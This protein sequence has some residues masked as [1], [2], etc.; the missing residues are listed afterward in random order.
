MQNIA[1]VD[2]VIEGVEY[3]EP[4]PGET[5]SG[6][7]VAPEAER[8]ADASSAETRARQADE[9]VRVC[10][11]LDIPCHTIRYDGFDIGSVLADH[12]VRE[13]TLRL[14]LGARVEGE[15]FTPDKLLVR[16]MSAG[17]WHIAGEVV[18]DRE[19][20]NFDS[21]GHFSF[22]LPGLTAWDSLADLAVEL[23]YVR[24]GTAETEFYVDSV[25]VDARYAVVDEGEELQLAPNILPEL[26]VLEDSRRPDMLLVGDERI[27]LPRTDAVPGDELVIRSDHDVYDGLTRVRSYL[28]VTNHGDTEMYADLVVRTGRHA[29][30][31]G[32]RERV[33]AVPQ[34]TLVPEYS[35]VAYL[36][37]GGW[38][39]GSMSQGVAA[40]SDVPADTNT[41]DGEEV[42]DGTASSSV[43]MTEALVSDGTGS[44]T[45]DD[46]G[47]DASGE[48]A[49]SEGEPYTCAA[50][51]EE[52]VCSSLN[53][54]ETNCIAEE[55]RI[56][57]TEEVAYREGWQ[58]VGLRPYR[59]RTSF[60]QRVLRSEATT[61]SELPN[62]VEAE[63]RVRLA[64][65]ETRFF[66]VDVEVGVQRAGEF[67]FE[68]RAGD[69]HAERRMWWRSGYSRRVPLTVPRVESEAPEVPLL[70]RV[71]IEEND[72]P[73]F[74]TTARLDGGDVRF[75]D[76]ALRLELPSKVVSFSYVEQ[77]AEYLVELGESSTQASSSIF[78]YYGNDTVMEASRMRA[79]SQTDTPIEYVRAAESATGAL[80]SVTS[81]RDGNTMRT[82]AGGTEV[83]LHEGEALDMVLG[84]EPL[85]ARGP[86]LIRPADTVSS[87][88]MRAF[89]LTLP[90]HT[91]SLAQGTS[92]LTYVVERYAS[93]S[94]EL[95]FGDVEELPVP[96]V[97]IFEPLSFTDQLSRILYLRSLTGPAYHDFLE[98]LRDF[99]LGDEVVFKLRYKP[100]RW[101]ITRF[102][103][104]LVRDRLATV[105]GVR[106]LYGGEVLTD[107][108]FDV[109][110]GAEGEWTIKLTEAPRSLVP[111]K[112]SVE[113]TIDEV[114]ELYTD[115]FDF[116]FGVL[117]VNTPEATYETGSVAE[118]HMAALDDRGDTIC[119]AELR[120]LITPPSGLAEEIPVE[121]S[122]TCGPNNVTDEPDYRALYRLRESGT[123]DLVL[124]HVN[125]E[126]EIVHQVRDAVHAA[127][128]MPYTIE[129]AG[130][131]RIWPKAP[132]TMHLTVSAR[133][134]W[135]G[136]LVEALPRDFVVTDA[137]GGESS[138]WGGAKRLSWELTL[139]A[140]ESVTLSYEYD[141]PDR[142][143]YLYLLGP[144]ELRV[145]EQ[146]AYRE[147]KSWKLASDALGQYTE[148]YV[149]FTP[150]VN[151]TWTTIDLSGAPY[152]IPANAILEIAI[153]NVDTGNE[154]YGGVRSGAST[155]LD[156]RVRIHEAE[157]SGSDVTTMFVQA[158][159]TSSIQY[160]SDDTNDIRFTILGYW[161]SGTYTE[162]WSV[163]GPAANNWTT[164]WNLNTYGVA[165]GNVA[166]IVLVN[167]DGSNEYAAGVRT[168]GSTL[169]REVTIHEPEQG[170]VDTA[171]ML[172][173]A[174]TSN[175][176]IRYRNA[177][178]AIDFYVAGFFSTLP[179]GL[180]YYER[181][182][183]LGGPASANTWTDRRLDDI[184][185]PNSAI[186]DVA[187]ANT[188]AD[189]TTVTI[190][191]RANGSSLSRT[192]ELHEAEAGG[193]NH[194]RSHVTAGSDAS[195]T[196]EYFT[197][198]TAYD[199]F[200]LAGYWAAANYPPDAPTLHDIPFDNEKTGSST[201]YF[202]FTASDPDGS[203]DIVYQVQWDD[204]ADLDASPLGDRSSDN[205]T[206]CSPNCFANTVSGG[207]TSPFTE[208]Q[209]I[210]FSIQSALTSGTT[211][212]WRVRAKDSSGS[213]IYS[214]WTEVRS[215]TYVADTNPKAWYQTADAQFDGGTFSGAETY[216]A[217]SVRLATTPPV[218]AMVAY[219]EGTV[220]TP[221]Y[222]I[223]N[224]TAWG[225]EL[226]AQSATG[227]ISW[228]V[229]RAAPTRDEY[230]LVTQTATGTVL[231]QVYNGT[232]GTWGN[233]R[234]MTSAAPSA[235]RR[236]VDVAYRGL[237]GEAVV[238][239][240]DGDTDP[241]TNIW[242]GTNWSA[243]TTLDTQFNSACNWVALA[244]SDAS[245]EIAAVVQADS[246][247]TTSDFEAQILTG[248]T[249]GNSYTGGSNTAG[250]EFLERMSIAYEESGTEAVVVVGNGGTASF[251]SAVWNTTA[252]T[253][254]ANANR[255][256][257]DDFEW[258]EFAVDDG[259]DN[260]GLCY[261]DEDNQVHIA[262]WNG[263]SNTWD[264]Y[265]AAGDQIDTG[266]KAN[267]TTDYHARP[268][269]CR[270]ETT[271]GRDGYLMVPYSDT[272]NAR[273]RVWSTSLTVEQSI[274]TIEDSWTVSSARTG[275]GLIL[276][277]WRDDT[278]DR[279]DFSYWNGNSWSAR[280]ALESSM[281]DDTEPYA[282]PAMIAAQRFQASAGSI[283]S[284]IIDFDSVPG[285]SS[286]GELLWTTTEPSGTDVVMQVYYATTTAVC[287]VL[288]PDAAL[289]GNSTGF[290][291][292][293]SPLNLSGL[294]TS[295]YNMLCLKASLSSQSSQ[296]STLDEW[297]VSWVRQPFLTQTAYR[298]YANTDA[299][300]PTDVWPVGSNSVA[301]NEAISTA[302]A[303]NVGDVLRLR[304][305]M[306][307]S[308]VTL[309][310]SSTAF[311]LQWAEGVSC[312]AS[313]DWQ[314]VGASGSSVAWRGYDN[315]S[316]SDG[317]TLSS[318]LLSTTDVS[319]S[320]EEVNDTATNTSAL[321]PTEEAEF[322]FVL[323][324][325][326]TS[327]TNY[328]FRLINDDGLPINQ[329]DRYPQLITNAPPST[330]VLATPF[331]YEALAS[332]TP[333]FTFV[334]ED[335]KGDDI[336]YEIEI[337][338]DPAFGSPL[339]RNSADHFNEFV[340]TVT[341]ADKSPFTSGEQVR[342][343][344]TTALT[345]N[346]T[347]WWRVHARDPSGSN[348]WSDWS[349]AWSFTASSTVSI[350]TWFQTTYEQFEENDHENTEATVSDD[351]ALI[352][353][354]TLG[355]TTAPGIK[356]AWKTTGNAW[357]SLS[358]TE[359]ETTG[360]LRT[361]VQYNNNGIWELIPDSVLSGNSVG[362]AAGPVSLLGLDPT[363]YSEIRPVAYLQD[364]SGSPRLLDWTLSWGL[365]VEQP[366]LTS[367]FDNEKVAT[368]TPSFTF[369]STDPQGNDLTYEIQ[370][371]AT[372]DFA[373]STTRT[374][375]THTG[376]TN[377]ASSTDTSPFLEDNIIRFT[378][379]GAD[380]LTN[381][382]TYWWRVRA[383]DPGG[384]DT[385]S[386][387]SPIRSLTVDT[388][389]TVSTWFQTTDE[390]FDTDFLT[391][392]ETYGSD[393]VRITSTIREALVAYAEG[394]VQTPRY[395][396]WN[397]NAWGTEK[398]AAN[399][400]ERIY[401]IRTAAGPA[402]DEY[403][404]VTG[405]LSGAVKA[406]VYNGTTGQWGDLVD[407]STPAA[408]NRRGF[409]VAY[410]S[411][412]GRAMAA[413]CRGADAVYRTW[414]GA[415]WSATSTINLGFTQNC[416]WLTLASD[417]TSNEIILAARA[418]TANTPYAFEA[419]VWNG[420]AWGNST[421]Q[422][423]M[424]STD[425]ENIGMAVA[426]E[427]SGDQALFVTS[428]GTN[429]N[430]HWRTWNGAWSG[431]SSTTTVDDLETPKIAQDAG[432]DALGLCYITNLNS[433][434]YMRWDG[435]K[436][437]SAPTQFSADSNSK[438]GGHAFDCA[439]ETTAGRDGYLMMPYTDG[440]LGYYRFH[441]TSTGL[442]AEA[443]LSSVTDS[444]SVESVRTG[445]G[446]ILAVFWDDANTQFDFSYWNGTAPW[447]AR[448]T[449]ET[450]VSTIVN[451]IVPVSLTP[452]RYT[453]FTS[454]TLVSDP[455][456]FS[457]G[458]GP[459]WGVASS[460]DT[461]PG[462]SEIRYQFEHSTDNGE[463]WA[464]IPDSALPGNSV[465]TT[466]NT[467]DLSALSYTTYDVI[468]YVANFAC[469][470]GDCPILHDWTIAWSEG[471]KVSGTA[472]G[473]DE[474][475]NVTSGTVAVAVNGAVQTGKTASISGG[476]W[477][478][479]NVTMFPGDTVHVW[480]Q[481]AADANEA[482]AVF[483]YDG[484]GDTTGVELF[485]RHLTIGSH[486]ATTTTN[487][488]IALYDNS[489]SGNEDLFFEVDSGNDLTVC[490]VG[491]CSDAELFVAQGYTY[492]P[493][494][495]SGGNV[496]THDMEIA[497]TLTADGNTLTVSG[498]WENRGIFTANSSSVILRAT[499]SQETLSSVGATTSAFNILTLGQTS[500]NATWTLAGPLEVDGNCTL[501]Y[502][503]LN[504]S[505]SA[506]FLGGNFSLAAGTT[507]LKST[508]TT[509]FD[510]TGVAVITDATAAKQDLGKVAASGTSKTVRLGSA[511]K[512]TD[513]TIYT[514]NTFD[515]SSN[516][517]AL[518]VRGDFRN[519]DSFS[520]R[521]GTVTM[522]ATTTGRTLV[523]GNS[524]LYDL[525]F[526]GVGG[527]WAFGQP[528]VTVQNNLTIATGT[529][530]LATGTTTVSGSLSNSGTLVHNN[531]TLELTGSGSKTLTQGGSPLYNLTVNGAGAWSWTEQNATS[532]GST[533][534]LNGTLTM[535]A[536]TYAV[537]K[538]FVN[539]G[540]TVAPNGGTLRFT[541]NV[542]ETVQANGSA[543]YGLTFDGAGGTFAL[544]DTN[545]VAS[546]TVRFVA[547][548]TTL[549]SG[550]MTVSGSWVTTGGTWNA[551]GGTVLF[552]SAATG[553]TV[554]TGTNNFASVTFNS[555]VGGWSIDSH[556]TSTGA[557]SLLAAQ[558]YT[559]ASGNTMAVGGAFVNNV[560][561]ATTWTGSTLALSSGTSYTVGSSSQA[562]ET[563]GTLRIGANTDVKFWQS[564]AASYAVDSTGS[565]YSQDHAAQNGDLYIWGEYVRT[566][567]TEHWSYATD[568][569]GTDIGGSPRQ[570][571]VRFA[572]GASAQFTGATLS[573]RGD[574]AATTTLA[575]QG[576]GSYRL[577]LTGST[578]L[579]EYF[580]VANT[581]ADG[582]ALMASTTVNY[583]RDGT[584][585]LD[586]QGGSMLTLASTT[587]DKN[588]LLQP[589]RLSFGTSTGISTGYNVTASG[590]A[591]SY[592]W[593]KNTSGNYDGESYDNDPVAGAGSIRWD[594]SG[595]TIN[596]SGT[597]YTGEGAGV[598]AYC[599]GS[600]QVLRLVVQGVTTYDTSC[601]AGT[602]AFTFSGVTYSGDVTFMAFLNGTSGR[603]A[604]VSRTPQGNIAG[605][606]LYQDRVIVRHEDTA[607][608][609]IANM[610]L[611]DADQ[612]LDI[613]FDAEAGSLTVSPE[614]G[615]HVWA[616]KTFAPSGNVT[617]QSG[618]SG[619]VQD[620]TLRLA[621][622]SV[623]TAAGSESHSIGGS[624]IANTGA[625]FTAANSTVNFT[626]TTT[627]KTIAP[628][629]SFHNL[630]F[631]GLNG[632]W[633]V[634]SSTQVAN[635]LA[636]SAGT[637]SGTGN[638][639]VD[640]GA[641]SG[642]GSVTMTG[643]T[644]TV[645][646]GG[647][648]GGNSTWTFNNLTLGDG[649]SGTTAKVGSGDIAVSGALTV[650]ANHIL[651]AGSYTWTLTGS[652]AVLLVPGTF[653]AQTSTTTFAG[654]GAMTVPALTYHNLVLAPTAAGSP[655]YTLAAGSLTANTVTVGN[656]T[657]PVTVQVNTNDPL[658]TV[659]GTF[660]NRTNATYQA[661]SAND[662]M[663]A[664]SY[665]NEGTFT[666]NGG[667]VVMN[668][669]DT[670][671]LVT[672]GASSFHHLTFN[673]ASGG[674]TITGNATTTGN[675]TLTAA[676]NFTQASGSTLRVEG[677]FL[678]SVG[679]GAT[680]WSGTTLA[681]YSGT[682]YSMNTKTTEGDTYGTLSVGTNTDVAMWNSTSSSYSISPSGSLYSQDHN[683]VDGALYIWGDYT[684]T[685][686][687]EHWSYATDFDGTDISGT[688]RQAKVYLAE[689]A[690]TTLSAGTWNILG[691]SG[692]TT[693]IQNQGSGVYGLK[694]AGGTF[695]AQYY[696]VRN[697]NALGLEFAGTPTVTSLSDGDLELGI[698]GGAMLTIP[699]SVIT[700]N[701]VKTW[702]RVSFATSS[703]VTSGRNATSS[704]T[705][706]SSWR[707]T[708]A[709]GNYYGEAYDGDPAG[710]PGY[711]IWDDS[712]AQVS[713][714]G[715]VYSNETGTVSALCNGS[716]QVVRMVIQGGS[717]QSTSCAAGTGAYLFTGVS[718]SP[719]DAIVV[720]LDNAAAKAAN[721]TVDPVTSIADMHLYESRVVVRHEDTNAITIA[722]LAVYDSDQDTDI[723]FDADTGSPNTLT[724][725]ANR[726]LIVW[727]GKTF[728]PGGNVTLTSGGSG[729]DYDGTL[730]LR[731][732]ATYVSS[733]S[734]AETISVG[735]SWLTGASASFTAGTSTVTFTATTSGK[736]VSPDRSAFNNLTF[737]GSGGAW[738]F[739][740]RDATT[741]RNFTLTAGS[742]TL[743]TS[744]LAVGG[745]FVNSGTL[746]AASTSIRFSAAAPATVT[747]G[748]ASVGSLTF[749]GAGAHTITD[750]SATSTGSVSITAG[751][752]ALPTSVFAVANGFSA[753]GG[754]FT[755]AGTLRLYGTLAAQTLRVGASTLRHLLI[756]GSGSW[757]FADTAATTTGTTTVRAG[758]LTAPSQTF[759][760]GGSFTNS[761]TY[762]S[763]G[764]T[765]RFYATTTGQTI[766]V[767]GALLAN[768]IISGT[769]GGWTVATS[770]TTTGAFR[771]QTATAFEMASSTALEVQGQFENTVGG[772]A[773]NWTDSRLYLNASG[774]SYAVNG[775]SSTGDTYAFLT[776]GPNTD[777][778]MWNSSAATTT[779]HAS[780]SLYAMDHA[781][782]DGSLY[783]WGEYVRSAG[784]EYWSYATDFDGAAL[785]GSARA[786]SV[787]V[788]S[789]STLTFTGGSLDMVGSTGATTSV[790]VIGTG[791]YS[792]VKS[793]GSLNAQ[794]YSFRNLTSQGLVL[795]NAITVTSLSYGDFELSTPNGVLLQ[796]ASSTIDQNPTKTIVGNRF[797]STSGITG[798]NVKVNGTTAN[799]WDFQ[800][801]YGEID[802]ESYDDD[803]VDACGAVRWDD[804]TCLEVSQAHFRFRND[805][806][807]GG[808]PD[809]E[810]YN[811]DWSK[812]VRLNV[813]NQNGTTLT[814]V[815]VRMEL[816]YDSD[817]QS[818]WN[819]IRFTDASGTTSLPYF[820]ER[821]TTSATATIWVKV[822]SIPANGYA[823]L[824]AYYGNAFAANDESG[825]NTFSSFDDFEDD[826]ISEYSGD[827]GVFDVVADS[828]AEGSYILKAG[829]GYENDQTTDG[830]YRTGTTFGQG[831]T[832]RF[833]QYVDATKDDEPC[834]LFGVQSPGSNNQNY[835]V[836]LDQ[837]PS[838]R[839]VLAK[840]VSSNDGSGTV[841]ASSSIAWSS[842]WYT[843]EVDWFTNN[844]IYVSVYNS[845]GSLVA[846]TTASDASYAS[847]GMG[848]SF[849]YQSG[850]WDF[851]TARPYAAVEPTLSSI[852]LEQGKSGASWKAA[853][854]V[855]VTQDQ[856]L[857][858]RVRF[859]VENSGP[860]I[861][862]KQWRLQYA[863]KTGYGTCNAVP[864]VSF[865]DVPT[866]SNCGTNAIC[867]TTTSQYADGDATQ[868]LLTSTTFYRYAG[869]KLIE[870][871]SNQTASS[872]LGQGELTEVEYAIE[873]TQNAVSNA[874]C[875]RVSD[876]GV[877]LDSYQTLAEVTANYGPQI[878]SWSLN[879]DE[880]I[881]LTEGQTTSVQAT[882]TI[883]DLNGFEDL[884]YATGTIYRSA[885]GANCGADLNNCYQLSSLSCPLENCDGTSCDVTCTADIQYFA[886]PTDPG[887]PHEAQSWLA[888]VFVVDLTGNEASS[889]APGVD[890]LTMRAV[891]V[892]TGGIGYGS[893]QVN[894]DTGSYNATSTLRNTGNT[895]VDIDIEGADLTAGAS[896]IP[897][898]NQK[899]ATS[900]FTYSA[901]AICTALS[902]TVSDYE[903]DLPKPTSTSTP[904]T[905]DLYWGIYVPSNA[906]GLTH[907]GQNT[908]Y[909]ISD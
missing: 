535:P 736:V 18:I 834:A 562:A 12:T 402:R 127:E 102:F 359:N 462:A 641:F 584:F 39:P 272:T 180:E 301:E 82:G 390:Q 461:T 133:E 600:T 823:S 538:S 315:A 150:T 219:G 210:R 7:E 663:I 407:M 398:S 783:I 550:T 349:V 95:R 521:A 385:W 292:T 363:L 838:D 530:T 853:Q 123:Y 758:A 791:A 313:M 238:T 8:G 797:A 694:V 330:P 413:A 821:Y 231:A 845:S 487:A 500:G 751:T 484:V 391:D 162:R 493:D 481:G 807:G 111:G 316:V 431:T 670:G 804:S 27:T 472:K 440:T 148:S 4:A 408:T 505:T 185:V 394:V 560:P 251:V 886:E 542:A 516:N 801:H 326:A 846:T 130:A 261:I 70:Y 250:E 835:A 559:V 527:N 699:A 743:G 234:V 47:P 439:Y 294:S 639:T 182:D 126:G 707:F 160:Y 811:A 903:L 467:V 563:Y 412:S 109:S 660:R 902:G 262:K 812:R 617:L 209:R 599:N 357:G 300:T 731:D 192:A 89:A 580:S 103:R 392:L 822:P 898:A 338:D 274:S 420:S 65:R 191:V 759:A 634:A 622:G 135:S 444:W 765:M 893:L 518:E 773:T 704:G 766:S 739:A 237:S 33:R 907:N 60:W 899:F 454:G 321:A 149:T 449:L 168:L 856:G 858:F 587:I 676:S 488:H 424:E 662:L 708:P 414:D 872:S 689:G 325:N 555:A 875:M 302:F 685:S 717:P 382:A 452:R 843:V 387:W 92:S 800:S 75:Y 62:A 520:A 644:V 890:M 504:G 647:N 167:T 254:T 90:A 692:A 270:Y 334:A 52:R 179:T 525:T 17:T 896:T 809:S 119:D 456:H 176:T 664:G 565:L 605:F 677:I 871:P 215:F 583:L 586:T 850:G 859:S 57:T 318:R 701:P 13:Y 244:A 897:A 198:N 494:S 317:A 878:T 223:W 351:V 14:S 282:E 726:K 397:G 195:S 296:S 573:L 874:Y 435:S 443:A 609:S 528:L 737:N 117:A 376:F 288:V 581:D 813:R 509:T 756:D 675:F 285:Q 557:W 597:V 615:L 88:E 747:F 702:Y 378:V 810:W 579:A 429:A 713:I 430:F 281:A 105:A 828:G 793:G 138:V 422:G 106:L 865:N 777:V 643:G 464:L 255:G 51:G 263:T 507:F 243:T 628:S 425:A 319:F 779:V 645:N 889:T 257:Q 68:L 905:D 299:N 3:A 152:S 885:L 517:Y 447:S 38:Q 132:Y 386:V 570:V 172:V 460:T 141:A 10:T 31:V 556:A 403:A 720:Y 860:T 799:F 369:R 16:Y 732:N 549:P 787:R 108:R 658:I 434:Y 757:A 883:T 312:S 218:G 833:L 441:N 519:S 360:T 455:I 87:K 888:K 533:R 760:I 144:A 332:T 601:A 193:Q 735:G 314:D 480:I 589:D 457:D 727:N 857:P 331:T 279:F 496:S 684:R 512:L 134:D 904:V 795:S 848:F 438:D 44:A 719:G 552:N 842:A 479:N 849:W 655:T 691:T 142:S 417:P 513:L 485:E 780:S 588:P 19:L 34:S 442:S 686:G 6:A 125:R 50:T 367:P 537:G 104:G 107:A 471:L 796:V 100:Q 22:P 190:G 308:N 113:L 543:L 501:S 681:L 228:T 260:L 636:V 84:E 868:E 595:F 712:N 710:D 827:T 880:P 395:R 181:W 840:N 421:A 785:G 380:A 852:G 626:A 547:G 328:C 368:V 202:E 752:V 603:G 706:A 203:S 884:L 775:K 794:Y 490:S 526:Q 21:G 366:T 690:S 240:C 26:A 606:D 679:G 837:Y 553:R 541:S 116:Y 637:V 492:R 782:V 320:Y 295:T 705:T 855:S 469:V 468:R 592:W 158:S 602:G 269:T 163:F 632:G 611:Y 303:P 514:G 249:W 226:S 448:Q 304:L 830:I 724:L 816:P 347:Y 761:A 419:Q 497:G 372:P 610:L 511:L 242:N 297:T 93:T 531:G 554:T 700:T 624:W 483:R 666:A 333:W 585:T 20:S 329:Y 508:G 187:Y 474:S 67:A 769:G 887:A 575:N 96:A 145:G 646:K 221:R 364:V 405:G 143:P 869:G 340:N 819:D 748:G 551:N 246:T 225:G 892:T 741:T 625:T 839:L 661:A 271:A 781:G 730:E 792:I 286:W 339:T 771:L 175:A 199:S 734:S 55:E 453:S 709:L 802:G 767:G 725:P 63:E 688:P 373:A 252:Q 593:F 393:Q 327:S 280:A 41:T 354:N 750:T 377:T 77:A 348:D 371:S 273:Y 201:P 818:N 683:S 836:C 574:A 806:G 745:S 638:V 650:S 651:E 649:T 298:W 657:H 140:G 566:S 594:D 616:A 112:Y 522:T 648:F 544:A 350:S 276:T 169:T 128:R 189:D 410:E 477:Q 680:T 177:N 764:G 499:S 342:F 510:G 697:V 324:H 36:C 672:P 233:A 73:G 42:E 863:D 729:T 798:T 388:S 53:D 486:D 239:Y 432:S 311:T 94:P 534:I 171:T 224:G 264:A 400:G 733:A 437:V 623:F 475:T 820:V 746:S 91:Y 11:V 716:T 613:P 506:L 335:I 139:A 572:S 629:G 48:T 9:D 399:I 633:S 854:D 844:S 847:G 495:A 640:L 344:P 183:D 247:N 156:R 66:A 64:P 178:A 548:T 217:N 136:T 803:G 482:A 211:Y 194:A 776:L 381:G 69:T 539:A 383:K 379:Q 470:S 43:S 545:L 71:R 374:S 768:V 266:G 723:P 278:N 451:P 37:E 618:G 654:T 245:D 256:T 346:T 740:D 45:L 864:E 80:V 72:V 309:A 159:A 711:L 49:D 608:L 436:F 146:A 345:D 236:A 222:Q 817:M 635:N 212:Y 895:G 754:S 529:V 86:L 418:N 465:G 665:I 851:Y 258:S 98:E 604:T 307:D 358:W 478:I 882:G 582:L 120:L 829:A 306:L 161:T 79:P 28:S 124:T 61:T 786:V 137:G 790:A 642:N 591:S 728:T 99:E 166:E 669:A 652:G 703:G 788:A 576:S 832:V 621:S 310:A 569:D 867:M 170:G 343:V 384:G 755:H 375:G 15:S 81:L 147:A 523:P 578:L 208:G 824:Y 389:I 503:T 275:D 129:R 815:P 659:A 814:D 698:T 607:A 78:A 774:T 305:G 568:F 894:S 873:L 458:T 546:G 630:S 153:S 571:D 268:V 567:G 336:H 564:S 687:T 473:Y 536:E 5:A 289:A 540:G 235:D 445:D 341:P 742:V 25:W 423:L 411:V 154:A 287:N 188:A 184:T 97:G 416:E 355:T 131:T 220:A 186:A 770:A 778:S 110:Y 241:S 207:D 901:C 678:N 722:D 74:F 83:T 337:D 173:R 283:V 428:N 114:G 356:F 232:S 718:Y 682:S 291:A 174:S 165:D 668:S 35:D 59:E 157:P 406:Q 213:N 862:G 323:Q 906:A 561:G 122:T 524:P 265:D 825:A 877:E 667:G 206:G 577:Q 253:W 56:S 230:V 891:S 54:D 696:R 204:D 656:G 900:T 85:Y 426:Y 196:I 115:T 866:V 30:V 401:W 277:L 200:R 290:Q 396:L 365:A 738:T 558:S 40:P 614:T 459:R 164:D 446:L 352:P 293:S 870:S 155:T 197:G 805:D 498:S 216:G 714:G 753:Q 227:R 784:A 415:S 46:V 409:D 370:W 612:D 502:G 361:R 427:E 715:N 101:G 620:G 721:V 674:W 284:P 908:F 29:E 450:N 619:A 826:S 1:P 23:E 627:G 671:E 831:S 749:A 695:N 151:D 808:A 353:S 861:Y 744:T 267:G 32:L 763:N 489:A 879:G 259:S 631:T 58:P 532:S 841:L 248:T 491:A 876:G 598:P 909:P 404:M 322:D 463:T 466:S 362:F 673:H 118:F 596:V 214:E 24:H 789:S 515:V 433:M 590:T 121:R 229:L 476:T 653:T 76:A 772:A 881:A 2:A 762:N 693:T 205:E